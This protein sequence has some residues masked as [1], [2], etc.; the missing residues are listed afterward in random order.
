MRFLRSVYT[1]V[2]YYLTLMLFGAFG[3]GLSLFC[4]LTGWA[5]RGEK[6]ERFVQRLIHRH[7]RLFLW[8]TD[9]AG[10]FHVRYHGF[11]GLSGGSQI[12]VA[13]HPGLTDI[14]YLLARLSEAVCIFKPAIR[15]NPVMG[16]AARAAGYL[17]ADGGPDMVRA[18][19]DKVAAGNTLVL[20]PEGTR[21]PQGESLGPWRPGFVLM[22]RRAGAP[23]QLVRITCDSNALTKGLA[24]WKNP[25]LPGHVEVTLGP[26]IVVP[27]EAD[28][29]EFAAQV[30]RWFRE[31]VAPLA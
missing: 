2:G 10:L 24:W 30:E 1:P 20:F 22:A 31:G 3:L 18:A 4:L 16:A 25:Q 29:A 17:S 5:L 19:A 15:R 12:V 23:I 7:F 27:P 13:N 28:T 6:G 8:W 11:E 21:T 9:V 26:R 14:T